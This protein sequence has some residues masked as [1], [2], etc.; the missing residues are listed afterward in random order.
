M[1]KPGTIC[2]DC[3]VQYRM[4]QIG[5]PVITLFLDP[6][7]P[8]ELWV[9]DLFICPGCGKL[10]VGAANYN[11]DQP[12]AR[13][14]DDNFQEKIDEAKRMATLANKHIIY[15]YEHPHQVPGKEAT[16]GSQRG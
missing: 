12:I 16:N 15:V 5:V 2:V 13:H 14:H 10:V 7:R 3:Q 8:Y 11:G 6:P 1:A 4:Y 9:S